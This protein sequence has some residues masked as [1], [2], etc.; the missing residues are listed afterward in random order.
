MKLTDYDLV[1]HTYFSSSNSFHYF[2]L[3]LLY[4][5]I[6]IISDDRQI[7]GRCHGPSKPTRILEQG[8]SE[9]A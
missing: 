5:F 3:L 6:Q 4:K 7:R 8:Y 2:S 9:R 1:V